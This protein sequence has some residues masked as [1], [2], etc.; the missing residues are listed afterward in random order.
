MLYLKGC[1][2]CK[3]DMHINRDMY[4]SYRECLQCGYMVDIEEPNKLLESLNL[5]AETAEKKKV[6]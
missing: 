2:R 6:A 1:A 3:G 5:A 4:G